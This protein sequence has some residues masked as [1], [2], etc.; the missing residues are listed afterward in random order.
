[1]L[2]AEINKFLW[3]NL[4]S[5]KKLK[6]FVKLPIE[7]Q[8]EELISEQEKILECLNLNNYFIMN[9]VRK[10]FKGDDLTVEPQRVSNLDRKE[11]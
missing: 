8:R 2:E 5:D 10:E 11:I 4:S 1:M 7:K 9:M 6:E 3:S